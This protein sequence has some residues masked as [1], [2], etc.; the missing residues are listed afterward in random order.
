MSRP[1]NQ[2][3]TERIE[4]A[5]DILQTATEDLECNVAKLRRLFKDELE[6][7]AANGR[8]DLQATDQGSLLFATVSS[9][10]EM[11]RADTQSVESINSIIRLIGN[12]CPA[13]DLETMSCRITA[14]KS[15]TQDLPGV[16]AAAKRWSNV[17]AHA[18]PLL[19]EMTAA[20]DGYKKVLHDTAR[21]SPPTAQTMAAL[22]PS[23][24]NTDLTK[25]LPDLKITPE[26]QWASS[27]AARLKKALDEAK[28]ES[29]KL[30]AVAA[31]RPASLTIVGIRRAGDQTG[32]QWFLH[33]TSYRSLLFLVKLH[34]NADG[35]LSVPNK[36]E[37]TTSLQLLGSLRADCFDSLLPKTFE[38][39]TMSALHVRGTTLKCIKEVSDATVGLESLHHALVQPPMAEIRKT[40]PPEPR[41]RIETVPSL[42]NV[43]PQEEDGVAA[44]GDPEADAGQ[45]A[46]LLSSGYGFGEDVMQSVEEA[47]TFDDELGTAAVEAAN[48]K[49]IQE[50]VS[51]D[52]AGA[53]GP[54]VGLLDEAVDLVRQMHGTSSLTAA[55]LE[56]EA[57]LLVIRQIEADKTAKRN[58]NKR[59]RAEDASV[60]SAALD[61][62]DQ[63]LSSDAAARR[64]STKQFRCFQ[65]DDTFFAEMFAGADAEEA[66]ATDGVDAALECE[67]WRN[68]Y[69]ANPEPEPLQKTAQTSASNQVKQSLFSGNSSDPD[70]STTSGCSPSLGDVSCTHLDQ[71]C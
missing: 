1:P 70:G 5:K 21:F 14:K 28:R 20:G 12:R 64:T 38:V 13:I 69:P 32:T 46:E 36:M 43:E 9:M 10:S 59:K 35:C 27:H 25:A 49:R 61:E 50:T 54:E 63:L 62:V 23:L 29:A 51:K 58:L 26:R 39:F 11:L 37:F 67:T 30:K 15:V 44:E 40:D 68:G 52:A 47:E 53:T 17:Y 16:G 8:F 42:Q 55:E 31:L 19:Q 57:L 60:S 65:N 2:R 3:C 33:A 71:F 66:E 4:V 18:K 48:A 22:E 6:F 34:V 56:E 24:A 7:V 45:D 41:R